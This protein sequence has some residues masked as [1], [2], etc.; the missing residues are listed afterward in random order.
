MRTKIVSLIL[1]AA[2][3]TGCGGTDESPLDTALLQLSVNRQKWNAAA[4]HNY[5]FD[6][7]FTAMV[8]SPPVHIEVVNDLVTK[9]T[10]R[11]TGAI[12]P[13][14]RAPTVDSLFARVEQLIRSPEPNVRV[15]YDSQLGFPGKIEESSTIPDTGSTAT[16]TN[17][18]QT[19]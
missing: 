19:P 4:V 1:I 14:T 10:D 2:S 12:Y 6:Y 17:F 5:S 3:L 8:F 7:D 16:V 15:T 11:G 18:Q 9:V 13:N